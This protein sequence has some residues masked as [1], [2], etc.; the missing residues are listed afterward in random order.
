MNYKI[1]FFL[2]IL[3]FALVCNVYSLE[4]GI[5]PGEIKFYGNVNEKICRNISI[6]TNYNESI[7]GE[8][9]W[10]KNFEKKRD[11]KDYELNS[12]DLSLVVDYIEKIKSKGISLKEQVCITATKPGK[13]YGAITYKT[14]TGYAGVGSWIEVD[15]KGDL[16]D[17]ATLSKITG[18]VIRTASKKFYKSIFALIFFVIFIMLLIMFLILLIIYKYSQEP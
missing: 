15:I 18:L 13:Y 12:D 10:I 1:L 2:I 14:E 7:L 4:L 17:R 11:I 9:R 3:Y 5:S 6:Q 8:T 16:E